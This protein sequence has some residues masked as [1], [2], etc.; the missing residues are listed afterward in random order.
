LPKLAI[1]PQSWYGNDGTI[2]PFIPSNTVTNFSRTLD[3][4]LSIFPKNSW[5]TWLK[6]IVLFILI[7]SNSFLPVEAGEL[8]DRVANFPN[9]RGL[10][11][12]LKSN[13]VV[14]YPEW[15]VGEWQAT[16]TLKSQLA[17]LAPDIVTPG[18]NSNQK[19]IDRPLSF[20]VRFFAET[21]R[22][23]IDPLTYPWQLPTQKSPKIIADRIFNSRNITKAYLGEKAI[24]DIRLNPRRS[25]EQI[26]EFADGKTLLSIVTGYRKENPKPDE[27]I[28]TEV[29][30]QIFQQEPQIYLNSVETTTTYKYSSQPNPHIEANQL[31]AI[32]LSPQDPQYF[33]A[34]QQP[35]ALY[36]YSLQLIKIDTPML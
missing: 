36:Q 17:P 3:Q 12:G 26:T 1:L 4:R 18:F 7:F 13:N 11:N 22:K 28:A 25:T 19:Y 34:K 8:A 24:A 10:P 29:S 14:D 15:F 9:W 35:V 21:E 31:T 6:I 23:Q 20:Q 33:Q 30:Q 27:F 16:S 2:K 5:Q 32:Y